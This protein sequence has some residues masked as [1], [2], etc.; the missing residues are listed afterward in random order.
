MYMHLLLI[1][2][3]TQRAVPSRALFGPRAYFV[4]AG[5]LSTIQ[6]TKYSF[7]RPSPIEAYDSGIVIKHVITMLDHNS[8]I[9]WFE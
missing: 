6:L 3:T 9:R 4:A 1:Y 2:Q 8:L 5:K 7:S